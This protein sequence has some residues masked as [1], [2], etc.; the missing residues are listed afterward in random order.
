MTLITPSSKLTLTKGNKSWSSR[1]C[2]STLVDPKNSARVGLC[3]PWPRACGASRGAAS[4]CCW[5][6]ISSWSLPAGTLTMGLSSRSCA[7]AASRRT[8]R[9]LGRRYGVTGERPYR[10][11]GSS[12]TAPS[13]WRTRLAVSGPIRKWTDSSSLSTIDTSA[14]A[15]SRAGPCGTLPTASSALSLRSPLRSRC[16]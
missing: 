15:P 14:S 1:A 7:S 8:W 2:R 12:L 5:L 4:G 11:M 3:L 9:L 13:T 16:S 6:T 10:A